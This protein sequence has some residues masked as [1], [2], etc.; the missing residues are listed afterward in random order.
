MKSRAWLALFLIVLAS[1]L[2]HGDTILVGAPNE[3]PYTFYPIWN[4]GI[5][6]AAEFTLSSNQAV[7]TIDLY[8]LGGPSDHYD[9]ALQNALTGS[10][11]TFATA[12]LTGAGNPA[13]VVTMNVNQVLPAGTYFLVG[14]TA[15]GYLGGWEVS[16]GVYIQNAGTVTDGIWQTLD[17]GATWT[18]V[19]PSTTI[20]GDGLLCPDCF[21]PEF[22][23]HG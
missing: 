13:Q 16:D 11:T 6:E 9:F 12:S 2:L 18:F 14:T 17:G 23:V 20:P 1:S 7:S 8:L 4:T 10:I 19:D 5:F 21:A 15:D 22:V 3:T